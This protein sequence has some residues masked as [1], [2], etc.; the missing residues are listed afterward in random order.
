MRDPIDALPEKPPVLG[1]DLAT[2][3]AAIRRLERD[4]G[5]APVTGVDLECAPI[6]QALPEEGLMRGRVHEV[7]GEMRSDVRDG[8]CFGFATALLTMLA[9]GRTGSIIWCPR[10]ANCLGGGLS[11]QG[12]AGFGLDPDRVVM[13]DA[14]DEADRLWVMEEALATAGVCAILA[15][16][17]PMTAAGA[18]STG[19]R[20]GATGLRRL[21]LAAEKSGV[22]GLIL[23]PRGVTARVRTDRPSGAVETR[24]RVTAAPSQMDTHDWRPIWSVALD[25]ARRGRMRP[26]E[27]WLVTWSS[28]GSFAGSTGRFE[29]LDHGGKTPAQTVPAQTMSAASMPG[30]IRAIRRVA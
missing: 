14:R 19:A 16:F 17:D 6:M 15:E 24:W 2:L 4:S 29:V 22:T 12:L 1:G 11:A 23:R 25:R 7:V 18:G 3:R 13:V 9:R 8:A 5:A 21:Q 20:G 10:D 26:A 30:D 27:P 28:G